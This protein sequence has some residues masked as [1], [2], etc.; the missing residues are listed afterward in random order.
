MMRLLLKSM[1]LAASRGAGTVSSRQGDIGAA[2][3]YIGLQ[4]I[5]WAVCPISQNEGFC[6]F[7]ARPSPGQQRKM[8]ILSCQFN[9]PYQLEVPYYKL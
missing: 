2:R 9:L 7:T 4:L 1:S 6:S 8:S 3:L 5:V